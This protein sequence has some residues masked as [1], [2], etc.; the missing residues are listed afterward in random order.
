LHIERLPVAGSFVFTPRIFPDDRG[1]FAEWFR[2]DLL[3]AELGHPVSLAQ[4]NWSTSRRGVIR[5][6]HYADV[7][8]GQAKYVTCT[9]GAVLD[10]VVDLRVGS[11]TFGRH[12]AVRL[13]GSTRRAVYLGEGLGHG[14]CALTDDATVL[15]LCSTGYNPTGEHGIHP[16]DP[17]L[18]LPWPTDIA[19]VLSPKDAEAP[20]LAA[21]GLAGAL[22]AHEDCL[23]WSQSLRDVA[24]VTAP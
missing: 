15:Y 22:P 5:G 13:D 14:F 8:P 4:A 9:R 17:D 24:A 2:Q 19:H 20:T 12:A 7:P 1:D 11:P 16:L 10:V 6:I 23:S 21:A 18:A 3:A